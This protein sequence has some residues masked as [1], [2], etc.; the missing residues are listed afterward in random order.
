MEIHPTIEES[1]DIDDV[2]NARHVHNKQKLEFDEVCMS[3]VESDIGELKETM[4]QVLH[5]NAKIR[6]MLLNFQGKEVVDNAKVSKSNQY[7]CF[8][9]FTKVT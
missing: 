9:Q 5:S 8:T 1:N 4:K 2:I 7:T 6:D 3:N